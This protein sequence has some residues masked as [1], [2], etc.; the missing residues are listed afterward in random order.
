MVVILPQQRFS[1]QLNYG[2]SYH[3]YSNRVSWVWVFLALPSFATK[4]RQ[5]HLKITDCKVLP[6]ARGLLC[7]CILDG[8]VSKERTRTGAGNPSNFENL[9]S[10]IFY[11]AN[12]QIGILI[13]HSR[14]LPTSGRFILDSTT[15]QYKDRYL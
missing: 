11:T 9:L 10:T 14:V 8:T 7:T 15:S 13:T 1:N 4:G 5:T 6:K 12:L 2:I 3:T